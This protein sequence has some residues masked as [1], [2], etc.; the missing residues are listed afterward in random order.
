MHRWL[1][2]DAGLIHF[3]LLDTD[4]YICVPVWPLAGKQAAWL[5]QDLASVDRE[6]TPW[7]VVLGHRPMY[8]TDYP[9]IPEC[10]LEASAIRCAPF[11]FRSI[12]AWF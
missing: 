3:V 2:F 12:G 10:H 5:R 1:S 9:L 4:A 11:P 8:C 7:V 6:K